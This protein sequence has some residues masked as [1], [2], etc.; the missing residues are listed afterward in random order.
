MDNKKYAYILFNTVKTLLKRLAIG[1]EIMFYVEGD[2]NSDSTKQGI[3]SR[4]SVRI[5]T[6]HFLHQFMLLTRTE[7]CVTQYDAT[8]MR[9][10]T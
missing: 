10:M 8:F 7:I 9:C 3:L 6:V 5:R 4:I 1:P 2:Q